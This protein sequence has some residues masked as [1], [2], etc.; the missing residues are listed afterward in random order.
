MAETGADILEI[1][2]KV[3]MAEAKRLV[4]DRVC[5]MGNLDPSEVLHR[6]SPERVEREAQSVISAAAPAGGLILGSGCEVSPLTPVENI[7]AM[8]SCGHRHAYC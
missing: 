6:G 1:D 3:D 5:L 2:A 4:G 8:V 7:R